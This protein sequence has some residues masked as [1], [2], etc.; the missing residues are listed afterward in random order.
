[1]GH[2][3]FTD[4]VLMSEALEKYLLEIQGAFK[5]SYCEPR[6]LAMQLLTPWSQIAVKDFKKSYMTEIRDYLS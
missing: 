3:E 1:M 2:D 5:E 6:R 4:T